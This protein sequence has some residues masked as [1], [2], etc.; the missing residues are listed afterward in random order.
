MLRCLNDYISC[1]H[2]LH[3][4]YFF[5]PSILEPTLIAFLHFG[6]ISLTLDTLRGAGISTICPFSPDLFGLMCFFL[7]FIPSTTTLPCFGKTSIT[8]PF[9]ALSLPEIIN[10]W[11]PFLIFIQL[12][13]E[14]FSLDYPARTVLDGLDDA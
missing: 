14:L 13:R 10:T 7:K 6:Q 3:I 5:F 8:F 1:P 2:F 12:H 9:L 4:L 11:S